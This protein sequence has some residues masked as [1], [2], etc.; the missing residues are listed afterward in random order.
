M[1]ERT[2]LFDPATEFPN[3]RARERYAAL[4]GLDHVKERLEKEARLLLNPGLLDDWSERN[5]GSVLPIVGQFH[6]RNPLF[7]FAGDVGTGKTALA[8]T[9]GDAVARSEK[10]GV[11][12]MRMSLNA[13]GSGRVG[14]MTTLIADAFQAVVER[15]DGQRAGRPSSAV[16]LLIDEADALAQSR[17]L[18]QMHHEDRAGVNALIRGVSRLANERLPAIAVLCTN[19]LNALDPAVQRRAAAIFTFERPESAQRQL[20]LARAFAGSGITEADL[21]RL[22]E[23]T[24]PNR[25]GYGFTYSDLTTRLIP[26]AVLDAFPDEPVTAKRVEELI[27]R[28]APTPPFAEGLSD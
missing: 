27:A 17:E 1:T 15:L 11:T 28:I 16:I 18:A 3:S 24:G 2:D 6:E 8:E 25:R 5:H 12:L 13:R 22:A 4:V 19:R 26:E 20:V 23:L 21:G 10:I 9:F 14:E 7:V